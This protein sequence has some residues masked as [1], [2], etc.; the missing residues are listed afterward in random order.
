MSRVEFQ[1]YWRD[2]HAPLVAQRA[3]VLGIHRYVQCHTM[4]DSAFAKF[5]Q[6][7]GQS[8]PFD[9]VAEI[10]RSDCMEGSLQERKRAAQD[11]LE[12]ERRFIDL[13]ESPA[14]FFYCRERGRQALTGACRNGRGPMARNVQ[15]SIHHPSKRRLH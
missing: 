6:A 7:R 8:V 4:D 11:L 12:D 15:E 2:V 3:R 13:S 5:A 9:G 10:W 14:L 1:A